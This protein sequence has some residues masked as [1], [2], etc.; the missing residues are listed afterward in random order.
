MLSYTFQQARPPPHL[1]APG[2][3]LYTEFLA[4]CMI[5]SNPYNSALEAKSA[6]MRTSHIRVTTEAQDGLSNLSKVIELVNDK[7]V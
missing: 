7:R 2:E 6:I 4:K 5:S 3:T 1:Q